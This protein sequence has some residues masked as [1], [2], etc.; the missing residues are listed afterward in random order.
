V[1]PGRT[2]SYERL[3]R[4]GDAGASSNPTSRG[5]RGDALSREVGDADVEDLAFF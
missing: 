3:A 4:V 5:Y 2:A 1:R